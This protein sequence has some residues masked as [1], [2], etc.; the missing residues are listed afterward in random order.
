MGPKAR[1]EYCV[2]KERS[3]LRQALCSLIQQHTVQDHDNT[4]SK[5]KEA[6]FEAVFKRWGVQCR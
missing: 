1:R 6:E 3:Q 2:V 4:D 5:F